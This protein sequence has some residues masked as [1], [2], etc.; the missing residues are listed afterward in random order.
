MSLV[1][2]TIKKTGLPY[3][4]DLNDIESF[5]KKFQNCKEES[6]ILQTAN[7]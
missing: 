4:G 1:F 3:P 5:N 2:S 7:W 6:Y